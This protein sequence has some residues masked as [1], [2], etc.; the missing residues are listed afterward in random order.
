MMASVANITSRGKRKAT[1]RSRTIAPE[2]SAIAP[3]GVK[4]HGCGARR[5]AA[6]R[7]IM[8]KIRMARSSR[9]SLSDF[10]MGILILL[11]GA[12]LNPVPASAMCLPRWGTAMLRPYRRFRREQVAVNEGVALDHFS[13]HY[14]NRFAE[15]G[16]VEDEG[17]EFAV[18]AAG[19]DA[20]GQVVKK[21]GVELA[22]G[23]AAVEHFGVYTGCDGAETVSVE[24]DG[25]RA[26][27]ACEDPKV[28]D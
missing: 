1:R 5:S 15:N 28:L 3:T 14:R 21:R 18:F 19:I 25:F 9:D 12:G 10:S 17:V 6:A 16:A 22:T 23:E 20:G 26:I 11:F 24:A 13:K 7:M 2:N 4:F 27:K 8:V